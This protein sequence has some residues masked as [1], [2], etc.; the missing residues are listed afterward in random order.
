VRSGVWLLE[1]VTARTSGPWA[2]GILMESRTALIYSPT[3]AFSSLI[4]LFRVDEFNINPLA[5]E[6][7]AD[8]TA[9]ALSRRITEGQKSLV[10]L[11]ARLTLAEFTLL[12]IIFIELWIHGGLSSD[13]SLGFERQTSNHLRPL[14]SR[15]FFSNG[16]RAERPNIEY[17]S[18]SSQFIFHNV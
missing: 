1:P 4:A 11:D 10:F 18:E 13:F 6:S 17:G 9:T 5:I 2:I 8:E 14:R 16:R 3:I 12:R 7:T 15:A